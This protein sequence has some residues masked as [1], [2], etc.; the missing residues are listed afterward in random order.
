MRKPA[1]AADHIMVAM[2]EIHGSFGT[3]ISRI[4]GQRGKELYRIMLIG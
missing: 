3:D 2:H 1:K 4:R